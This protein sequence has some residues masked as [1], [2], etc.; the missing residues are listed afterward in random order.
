[1]NRELRVFVLFCVLFL[2]LICF[3]MKHIQWRGQSE[4]CGEI[5]LHQSK[6]AL[7]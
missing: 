2:F 3:W 5:Y 4:N 6:H 1:M 7:H